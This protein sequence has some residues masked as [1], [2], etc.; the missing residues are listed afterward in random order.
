MS[1]LTD[2]TLEIAVIALQFSATEL[3]KAHAQS[4]A[5]VLKV[6]ADA[7][8]AARQEIRAFIDSPE[9]A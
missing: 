7:Q 3:R 1:T 2:K 9:H 8:D 4:G 6:A 5:A